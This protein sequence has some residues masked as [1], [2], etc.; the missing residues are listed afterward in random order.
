M[1]ANQQAFT[2][3]G[4]VGRSL[5]LKADAL[6]L[7]DGDAVGTWADSSGNARDAVQASAGNKPVFKTNI[8]NG[9]P[10]VRF[11]GVNHQFLRTAAFSSVFT[12]TTIFI[13]GK[14]TGNG[15]TT[16][17]IDGITSNHRQHML[18]VTAKYWM[19]AGTDL[20]GGTADTNY[21]VIVSNFNGASSSI[22]VDG[23]SIVTGNAGT[24]GMDGATIG[25][26]YVADTLGN[27]ANHTGD[28]AE[29][30]VYSPTLSA[31]DREIVEDV[32]GAKYAITMA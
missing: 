29:V 7:N 14:G 28:I 20:N 25:S 9:K 16:R 26:D 12:S 21:H 5:W 31:V 1:S 18:Y 27:G 30:I 24:N 19:T 22:F 6:A 3:S 15:V 10:V 13:V 11:D 4:I 8:L 32:L 23:T 17:Y 2:V